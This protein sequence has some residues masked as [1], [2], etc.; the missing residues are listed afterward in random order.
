MGLD[1]DDMRD[2]FLMGHARFEAWKL[3]FHNIVWG[4]D[5]R[6]KIKIFIEETPPEVLSIMKA[7]NPEAYAAVMEEG[8]KSEKEEGHARTK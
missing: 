8:G 6:R 3:G 1:F 7:N 5:I 2:S 4:D